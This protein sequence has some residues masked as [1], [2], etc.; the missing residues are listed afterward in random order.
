MLVGYAVTARVCTAQ[1]FSDGPPAVDEHEY[2]L[3]LTAG[4]SRYVEGGTIAEVV[5][6]ARNPFTR[7]IV[8]DKGLQQGIRAGMPVID[9]AGVVG[10]VTSVGTFTSEVTLVTELLDQEVIATD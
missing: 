6:T 1:S 9:G 4:K 8:V 2:L 7:K 10:Q 5:Y 3:G